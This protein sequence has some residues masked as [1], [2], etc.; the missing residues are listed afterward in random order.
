[1]SGKNKRTDEAMERAR[2]AAAQ[3]KP[4]AEQVKPFAKSTSAAAQ[5]QLRKTRA[6]A[7]PHVERTGQTLQH[8]VA[9][10]AAAMLSKAAE[11]IEPSEPSGKR[12]RLPVGVA[13]GVAAAASAVAAFIRR[14]SNGS[15][16]GPGN[17]VAGADAPEHDAES[18]P[19][20]APR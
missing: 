18:E 2:D 8:K 6:W 10:K 12:W 9:P 11:R 4:V 15:G 13:A 1:M 14:R 17:G 16:G 19:A 20:T 3:L 5:R 7:A